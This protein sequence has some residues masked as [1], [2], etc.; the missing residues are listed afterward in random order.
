MTEHET[1][2]I[3]SAGWQM[4]RRIHTSSFHLMDWENFVSESRLIYSANRDYSIDEADDGRALF[5][6]KLLL[7]LGDEAELLENSI[8]DETWKM[9]ST[10]YNRAWKFYKKFSGNQEDFLRNGIAEYY[11]YLAQQQTPSS[12]FESL[13]RILYTELFRTHHPQ[14]KLIIRDLMNVSKAVP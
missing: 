7:L 9:I 3:F 11:K 10:E 6:K 1:Y 4:L 5:T 2:I 8:S 14:Y 13:L 12:F